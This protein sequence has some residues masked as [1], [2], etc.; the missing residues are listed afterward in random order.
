MLQYGKLPVC[1]VWD[2]PFS[3]YTAIRTLKL[4]NFEKSRVNLNV[5]INR[6]V[7][8]KSAG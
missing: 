6:C 5:W 7:G 2:Y 3:V 1:L 8:A 4:H